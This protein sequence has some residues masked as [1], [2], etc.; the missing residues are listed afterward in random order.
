M[1]A[2]VGEEATMKESNLMAGLSWKQGFLSNKSKGKMST[3]T[4]G[5]QN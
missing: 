4:C 2:P 5:K 3:Q 1:Y